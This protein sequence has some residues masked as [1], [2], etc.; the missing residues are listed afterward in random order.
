MKPG[1][2]GILLTA[3]FL[4]ISAFAQKADRT[5]PAPLYAD[6]VYNGTRDP[7]IIYKPYAKERRLHVS[8]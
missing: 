8:C 5:P 7:E 2:L 6:P 1:I 4:Q 3:S